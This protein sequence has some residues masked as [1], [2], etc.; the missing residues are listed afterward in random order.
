MSDTV[1]VILP[2][3]FDR[4]SD[5]TLWLVRALHSVLEQTV[6]PLEILIGADDGAILHW[7]SSAAMRDAF[8]VVNS[9][10]KGHQ[11]ACNTAAHIAQGRWLA[12]L[13]DD[14]LHL[15]KYLETSLSAA[16]NGNYRFVS[17][18]QREVTGPMLGAAFDFPT[19]SSWLIERTL[20]NEIGG[21]PTNLFVH[22]DHYPLGKMNA[23]KVRRA[24]LIEKDAVPTPQRIAWLANLARNATLIEMDE[25]DLLVRRE[26]RPDSIM[27]KVAREER[28]ASR[29]VMEYAFLEVTFGEIPW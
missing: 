4:R 14:D 20:W 24:H 17:Q 5:G 19:M 6:K 2:S 7:D 22:H 13:E 23:G 27:A 3:K 8:K 29:S 26:I 25:P 15:P 28:Y 16:L 21:V 12:F 1:S 11:R 10:G 18:S 9:G